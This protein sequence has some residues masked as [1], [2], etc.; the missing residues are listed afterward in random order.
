MIRTH[1]P[2]DDEPQPPT[3]DAIPR[4]PFGRAKD[5]VSVLGVGGHHLGDCKTVEEAIQLVHEAIDAGV[6][7]F[8]NCWEYYNGRSENWLGRGLVGKR[9]KVFLM[10]KVCTHGRGADLALTMLEESLRRLGTDHL[11]LW[12]IHGVTF[13]NDPEL[14]YAKGGVLEAFDKAKKSGKVRYVGFTGHKDPRIHLDMIRRGY[15]FDSV[16]MPLNPLDANFRS[17][18]NL[19]VPEAKKRGMA[20]LG[21]K[22][23]GGT[24][25]VVKKGLVT[26]EECLRYALSLPTTTVISGMDS[27][28]VLRK[29]LAIARGFKPWGEEQMKAVRD[30][31]AEVAGDGRFETYKVSLRYDN[32]EA[33]IVHDFPLDNTQKEVKEMFNREAGSP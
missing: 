29:N 27:V 18:Q 19:V 15:P 30:K 32:P 6:N 22:S 2:T 5:Q 11:D 28:A 3:D 9:D 4:R 31:V 20:V 24:G 23:V 14:A 17:F 13:D 1:R 10:T 33:R 12:Q 8:D 25:D 16:Q 26:A 7:F 21:M